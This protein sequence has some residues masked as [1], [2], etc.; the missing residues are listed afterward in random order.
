MKLESVGGRKLVPWE[1]SYGAG[2]PRASVRL[3]DLS[4]RGLADVIVQIVNSR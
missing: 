2:E 4:S 1:E 3:A